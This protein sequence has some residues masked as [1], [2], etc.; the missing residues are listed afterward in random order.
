MSTFIKPSPEDNFNTYLTS[1]SSNSILSNTNQQNVLPPGITPSFP[2]LLSDSKK[3]NNNIEVNKTGGAILGQRSTKKDIGI[4][5]TSNDTIK[6]YS[7]ESVDK[8]MLYEGVVIRNHNNNKAK[9]NKLS[10]THY[11][12]NSNLLISSHLRNV[13]SNHTDEVTIINRA[14]NKSQKIN[15]NRKSCNI[16]LLNNLDRSVI[17][18]NKNIMSKSFNNEYQSDFRYNIMGNEFSSCGHNQEECFGT[19]KI[20]DED[21][22]F[23]KPINKFEQNSMRF[24]AEVYKLSN[25]REEW[26]NLSN[27]ILTITSIERYHI[28]Q[29]FFDITGFNTHNQI[30]FTSHISSTSSV[31]KSSDRF[32]IWNHEQTIYGLNFLLSKDANEFC[33]ILSSRIMKKPLINNSIVA[34][35]SIIIESLEKDNGNIVEIVE[36]KEVIFKHCLLTVQ[37][38][39]LILLI[40]IKEED[41]SYAVE[42]LDCIVLYDSLSAF[43]YLCHPTKVFIFKCE[44][45]KLMYHFFVKA[46]HDSNVSLSG[47]RDPFL[48]K[49]ILKT[50]QCEIDDIE[51]INTSKGEE[52]IEN[53]EILLNN[54]AKHFLNFMFNMRIYVE[55][56]RMLLDDKILL[57]QVSC[58][59]AMFVTKRHALAFTHLY[60]AANRNIS[61]KKYFSLE[62]QQYI[63][64]M[65]RSTGLW[66]LKNDEKNLSF[67]EK[68]YC[69]YENK[70]KNSKSTD[71]INSIIEPFEPTTPQ[72]LSVA[73]LKAM[74]ML[75][76][77]NNKKNSMNDSYYDKSEKS[78]NNKNDKKKRFAETYVISKLNEKKEELLVRNVIELVESEQAFVKDLNDLKNE[79]VDILGSQL[80]LIINELSNLHNYF[81]NC[82]EEAK[83]DLT[84]NKDDD[85][86][87]F[88]CQAKDTIMRVCALFINKSSRFK[89]Y[90]DYSAA[91]SVWLQ[92]SQRDNQLKEKLKQKMKDNSQDGKNIESLLIKPIQRILRYPLFLEKIVDSCNAET[93]EYKQSKQ[94]LLRL[95]ELASYINE[96]QRFREQFGLRL[97]EFAKNNLKYF[98]E[99]GMNI[100]MRELLMF[101]HI[102]LYVM[103]IKEKGSKRSE[104]VILIFN[105]VVLIF[106]PE[107]KKDKSHKIIPINECIV[108]SSFNQL[109]ESSKSV[110][111]VKEDLEN[112]FQIMHTD[113]FQ[114]NQNIY[115]IHCN[116]KEIKTQLLKNLHK[117]IKLKSNGKGVR[118]LSGTSQSD[119]GYESEK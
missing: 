4:S 76:G 73:N 15:K 36:N 90:S 91:Y 119:R 93:I 9:K 103:N 31:K 24:S 66:N 84:V 116:C 94:A 78:S 114:K 47:E 19:N 2:K 60:C 74:F 89:I 106:I 25:D 65:K 33:A 69:T 83:D 63:K 29:T 49:K 57:S 18:N 99:K 6:Q 3:L 30:V 27:G 34:E 44:R 104:G 108:I 12:D 87:K 105:T 62:N 16:G 81:L 38:N 54:V 21:I 52:K 101:S 35:T 107:K 42:M 77:K 112:M 79:S 64:M 115:V 1:Y 8:N 13:V 37:N 48:I 20:I 39:G 43:M 98:K 32:V 102:K 11:I 117:A 70:I 68:S 82:L 17:I 53:E 10:I 55:E 40:K 67:H 14:N 113:P 95:H 92:K 97:D 58:I 7:I 61:I 110:S 96:M 111:L 23:T 45:P 75:E 56:K 86:Y 5:L 71:A 51:K 50:A 109:M 100:D 46:I 85:D 88:H 59:A 118:P 22:C 41:V 26:Q 28:L 72:E 80:K